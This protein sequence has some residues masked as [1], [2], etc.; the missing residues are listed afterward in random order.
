M[1]PQDERPVEFQR[2]CSTYDDDCEST[3]E[4]DAEDFDDD[5]CPSEFLDVEAGA[6]PMPVPGE[7]DHP[8]EGSQCE[9]EDERQGQE[10]AGAEW[11]EVEVGDP[12]QTTE[13]ADNLPAG[14]KLRKKHAHQDVA[15]LCWSEV[16]L[17]Y[18]G[19]CSCLLRVCHKGICPAIVHPMGVCATCN[20]L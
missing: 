3:N 18:V 13:T 6:V 20:G 5:E 7:D 14:A 10:D 11:E 9:S 8:A 17:R 15:S 1:N 12:A 19:K 16:M 4:S 2:L